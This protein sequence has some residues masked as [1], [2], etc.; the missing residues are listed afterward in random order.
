MSITGEPD[1]EGG[2]PT[3]S[4]SRSRRHHRD[5]RRGRCPGG[6]PG[7]AARARQPWPG[8]QRVDVSFLGATMASLVNQ[9]QNAFATRVAPGRLGNAHPNIVPYE[10]FDTADGAIVVAVGSERQWARVCAALGLAELAADPWFVTNGD[11]VE[12]RA[13]LRRA[14]RRASASGPNAAWLRALAGAGVPA[15]PINDIVEAFDSP[16]AAA[17]GMT[18]DAGAP[19]R[20]ARS[21]RWASRSRSRRRRHRS[22]RPRRPSAST[23]TRSCRASA[24]TP[25]AIA[26]SGP[27]GSSD[28]AGYNS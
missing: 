17:L 1:G 16:E 10:T 12:H 7:R 9:A 6:G 26:T 18:V 8:G 2:G 19:G 24:T 4:G 28:D 3:R 13:A 25:A 21:A 14:S 22:G 15:G 5:A 27:A 11:R 23:P 20:G